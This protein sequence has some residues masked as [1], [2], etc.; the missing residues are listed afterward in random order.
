MRT[1]VKNADRKA[2]NEFILE[3]AD[4]DEDFQADFIAR[5]TSSPDKD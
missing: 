4:D 3:Y 2:L 1:I 5:F